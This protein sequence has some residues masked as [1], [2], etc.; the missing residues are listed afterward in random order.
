MTECIAPAGAAGSATVIDMQRFRSGKSLSPIRQAEAYWTALRDGPEIPRRTQIDPRGL[1]NLLEYAFILERIAPGIARFRLAGQHL[2]TLAGMEVR[3]MP[4]T[5]FFAPESRGAI[6]SALEHMFTAPAVTEL[7]LASAPRGGAASV[8]AQAIL[9]PLKNDLDDIS[10]ALGVL[11]ADHGVGPAPVRFDIASTS[12]R[13]VSGLHYE[14]ADTP[15]LGKASAKGLAE[16]A[17]PFDATRAP[18]LRLVETPE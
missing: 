7:S 2:T 13:A 14:G 16:P 1:E 3:G 9:L 6:A 12:F 17:E 8:A 5:A 4:M 18:H 15:A 11:I 10:R